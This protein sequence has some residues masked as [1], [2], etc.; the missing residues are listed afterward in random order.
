[1]QSQEYLDGIDAYAEGNPI[2]DNPYEK[3]EWNGSYIDWNR[4]W[5]DAEKQSRDEGR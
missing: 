4:G 2:D 1:M 3:A 5:R